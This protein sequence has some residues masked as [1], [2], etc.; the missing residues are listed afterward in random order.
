V[1]NLQFRR[2]F[3]GRTLPAVTLRATPDRPGLAL[4]DNFLEVHLESFAA[5][6]QNVQILVTGLSDGG[7]TGRLRV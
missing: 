7:L 5:A 6:N 3:V 1:R 2:L 4:S